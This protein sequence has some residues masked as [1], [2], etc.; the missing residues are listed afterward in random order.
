MIL[1][2][3]SQMSTFPLMSWKIDMSPALYF[4]FSHIRVMSPLTKAMSG[5]PK[6][7]LKSEDVR[8]P[9]RTEMDGDGED[10]QPSSRARREYNP[11]SS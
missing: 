6:S 10:R 1:L 9:S 3:F 5:Y 7:L 4:G 2:Y 8:D 11:L